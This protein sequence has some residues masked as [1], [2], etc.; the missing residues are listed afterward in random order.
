MKNPALPDRAFLSNPPFP[1]ISTDFQ[2]RCPPKNGLTGMSRADLPAKGET[3]NLAWVVMCGRMGF[4]S[5]LRGA[6]VLKFGGVSLLKPFWG[7][8]FFWEGG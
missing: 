7:G 2:L 1:L 3:K 5:G 4:S 8:R 6:Y